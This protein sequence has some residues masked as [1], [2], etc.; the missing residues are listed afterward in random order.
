MAI[1]QKPMTAPDTDALRAENAALLAR[2]EAAERVA[3][4]ATAWHQARLHACAAPMG[5]AQ[6]WIDLGAAEAA[7]SQA[8]GQAARTTPSPQET[9][10]AQD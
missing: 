1:I 4:A 9:S 3:Q 7:L 8:I 2:V 10:H 5:V 6:V